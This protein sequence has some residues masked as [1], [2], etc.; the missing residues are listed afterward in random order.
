M[1]FPLP[2]VLVP[3]ALLEGLFSNTSDLASRIGSVALDASTAKKQASSHALSIL[4]RIA[5]DPAFSREAVGITDAMTAM[6]KVIEKCL[7][8]LLP[9]LGEWTVGTTRKELDE[10]MEELIWM[11]TV[12]YAIGGRGDK[13][14]SDDPAKELNGDFILSVFHLHCRSSHSLFNFAHRMHLVTSALFVPSLTSYLPPASAAFFLRTYFLTS[15][16]IYIMRGRPD[17]PLAEFFANTPTLLSP[18]GSHPTPSTDVC[19]RPID[20]PAQRDNWLAAKGH[21]ILFPN[22]WLPIMQSTLVHP[23]DHLCKINRALWH[24]GSVFG[25][26]PAGTFAHLKGDLGDAEVLDG[27]LFVRAAILTMNRLGWVREG[28]AQKFW[29][30]PGFLNFAHA[31][32]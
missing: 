26:T 9:L 3:D 1:E 17:L 25:T 14:K 27:S 7:D 2:S 8:K 29:D 20:L 23:D 30:H 32:R 13:E 6:K 16:V 24:F 11:A 5:K 10:K 4:G 28:E 19:N 15:L 31:R 22:P 18:P 21:E 12:I